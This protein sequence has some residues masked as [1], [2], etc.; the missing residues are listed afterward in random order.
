MFSTYSRK[1]CCSFA[2]NEIF[3]KIKMAAKVADMLVKTAFAMAIVL[4]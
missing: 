3:E 4:N 1:I 2:R